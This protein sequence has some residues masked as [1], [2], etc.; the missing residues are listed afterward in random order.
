MKDYREDYPEDSHPQGLLAATPEVFQYSH[1]IAQFYN[2]TFGHSLSSATNKGLQIEFLM[3][4]DPTAVSGLVYL[5][6]LSCQIG[7]VPGILPAIRLRRM[8]TNSDQYV[9]ID[10]P[11]LLEMCSINSRQ[12]FEFQGFDPTKS[13]DQLMEM[14]SSKLTLAGSFSQAFNVLTLGISETV[15]V[16]WEVR[17]FSSDRTY[18]FH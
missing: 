10:M 16:D 2:E 8:N 3:C 15:Y 17:T 4:L 9:R 7:K 11:R 13:Q 6:V 1:T 18:N 14:H 5:A 12:R